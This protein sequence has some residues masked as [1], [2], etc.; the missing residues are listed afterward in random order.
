MKS[1]SSE[2]GATYRDSPLW[3]YI[4]RAITVHPLGGA[5]MG[6]DSST[7]VVDRYGQAFG[8]DGLFV[9]DGAA[10]PGAIGPNP[11][12]TIA[13]Y[14]DWVSEAIIDGRTARR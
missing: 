11:A 7:G 6:R 5:P 13:A 2:L 3:R 14:A 10:M 8:Q 1:I 9:V 4:R 12:L